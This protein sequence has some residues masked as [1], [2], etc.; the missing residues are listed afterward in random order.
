MNLSKPVLFT[1]LALCAALLL[2]PPGGLHASGDGARE[3]RSLENTVFDRGER[4]D[5]MV[6]YNSRLTGNV[7]AGEA[8]LEVQPTTMFVNGRPTMHVVGL[9]NSRG[10][11][12]FF[13]KVE[14]RYDTYIDN[15]AIAPLRFSRNIR[16]G[17]YSR[18]EQVSFDHIGGKAVSNRST[19][20]ILPYT[21]DLISSFYYARTLDISGSRPGDAFSV[22][23]FFGD[24]VY[25][26]RIVYEGREEVTTRMGTFNTL[27]FKPEV[28]EGQVFS[29]PYPMTMWVSDDRNR[30]PIL[31]ESDLVVG[32]I[33]MELTDF[34]GLKHPLLS[35]LQ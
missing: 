24:T 7:R 17:N 19:T 29:Q 8:S 11:F 20:E 27:K 14:N 3:M 15:S 2:L 32:N 6:Y 26:S 33:R 34:S 16:E 31:I 28:L 4:M 22:D 25:V 21:Q 9:V 5:F 35:R 18:D 1:V 30:V 13:F 23:F 10:V 12:N